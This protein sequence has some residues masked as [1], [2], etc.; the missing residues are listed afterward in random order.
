MS[1]REPCE[2]EDDMLHCTLNIVLHSHT[3]ELAVVTYI[4][5]S[6]GSVVNMRGGGRL[7]E[8]E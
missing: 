2:G 5:I 3:S 6:V 8:L 1:A 4:H 7:V